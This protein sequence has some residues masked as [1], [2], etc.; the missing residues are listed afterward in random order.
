[1][2]TFTQLKCWL[3]DAY[4]TAKSA[5]RSFWDRL[6]REPEYA[7]AAAT[8]MVCAVE[9]ARPYPAIL[10]RVQ[11]LIRILAAFIRLASQQRARDLPWQFA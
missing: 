2:N 8:L 6:V 5:L 4:L 7:D 11:R 1:L 3:R 10:G 9:L